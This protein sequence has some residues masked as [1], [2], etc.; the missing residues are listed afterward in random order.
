MAE[1]NIRSRM[2]AA[3]PRLNDQ[4]RSA[5]AALRP[6]IFLG[7]PRQRRLR[8]RKNPRNDQMEN[9]SQ[10]S[11]LRLAGECISQRGMPNSVAVCPT[12]DYLSRRMPLDFFAA[13]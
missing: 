8:S 3:A 9:A 1:C 12:A 10:E 11:W 5:G 2:Q 4:P 13:F 7:Q 6:S